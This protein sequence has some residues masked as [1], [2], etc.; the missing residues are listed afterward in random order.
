MKVHM[1]T[2]H[3]IT[4]EEHEKP[5]YVPDHLLVHCDGETFLKL[6]THDANHK[7]MSFL[8]VS[9]DSCQKYCLTRMPGYQKLLNTRNAKA[10]GK[11][12]GAAASCG[13]AAPKPLGRRQRAVM[14]QHVQ[15]LKHKPESMSMS[16][17]GKEVKVLQPEHP[18]SNL[19]IHL[20]GQSLT[21]LLGFLEAKSFGDAI[22]KRKY[23][24]LSSAT[25]GSGDEAPDALE[26]AV[27]DLEPDDDV[28][29]TAVD[30]HVEAPDDWEE[31]LDNLE[32]EVCGCIPVL[33]LGSI[34]PE[35][36][37]YRDGVQHKNQFP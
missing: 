30:D 14:A 2:T 15:A 29:D 34:G 24:K 17:N 8:G 12:S 1:L 33:S 20:T 31:T 32:A 22:K 18:G 5:W 23:E 25:C 36:K 6:G 21:A 26:D 13:V 3:A 35:V 27:K 28:S 37:S 9:S 7:I 19:S 11:V 16:I 4:T 10:F